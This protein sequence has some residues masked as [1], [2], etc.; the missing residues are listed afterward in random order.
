MASSRRRANRIVSIM[1]GGKRLEKKEEIIFHI[2]DYFQSQF[3]DDGWER[4]HLGNIAFE[5][6]GEEEPKWLERNFE[7]EE[8]R[9][10]VF[11]LARDKAPGPDGFPMAFFQRFWKMVKKDVIDFL[12]EF[13]RRGKLSKGL[14]A[15]F[16]ALVPKK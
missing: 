7:E 4:P 1:D 8:V 13:S 9:Q 12:E 11:G 6:I 3:S 5:V 14:G 15:S 16:I 2:L 10:V